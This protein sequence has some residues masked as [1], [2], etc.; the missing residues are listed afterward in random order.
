MRHQGIGRALFGV[1]SLGALIIVASMILSA[2]GGSAV[3]KA[4]FGKVKT[5]AVLVFTVPSDIEYRADPK[6]TSKSLLQQ[7]IQAVAKGDSN[8]A[9]SLSYETF[10][11]GLNGTGLPFRVLSADEVR[12]NAAFNA[13]NPPSFSLKAKKD[14]SALGKA[15]SFMG[16][17]KAAG[18]GVGPDG[19]PQFGMV[20][21]YGVSPLSGSD[22]EKRYL[23]AAMKALNVDAAIV[24][25]DH[26]YS[27]SCNA[28][29]GGTGDGSTGSAFSSAMV[30]REGKL[31]AGVN[32]W[33]GVSGGHAAMVGYAVNPLQ[34]DSLFK[35]HGG[36]MA[37]VYIAQLK[38]DGAIPGKK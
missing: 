19:L 36:R 10:T 20:G 37:E 33:F 3:N 29:V 27:F 35:A 23:S 9:A 7:V 26:G 16:G 15:M 11:A 24:V 18:I 12:N 8:R 30:N 17:P 38:D 32:Q 34:H 5:A 2:C 21:G 22:D 14:D 25:I 1:A 31:I 28:C 4:E 13:L 6:E